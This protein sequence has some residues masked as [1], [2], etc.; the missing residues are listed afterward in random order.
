MKSLV[1]KKRVLTACL[2]GV[3][4]LSAA[5]CGEV[6]TANQAMP[7]P[8]DNDAM[9]QLST[10]TALVSGDYYGSVTVEDLLKRGDFGLGCFDAV[11]GEMIIND[12]VCYQALGDG[13]VQKADMNEKVPFA[14]L[15]KFENDFSEETGECADINALTEFLNG[16][17]EKRGANSMYAVKIHTTCPKLHVRSETKQEEPYIPLNEALKVSQTEFDYD[18]AT[19]TLVCLYFPEYMS[20][21]NSAGWHF[22]FISDDGTQG[23]HVLDLSFDNATAEFDEASE[24]DM[25]VPE[26]D[27]FQ[28]AGIDKVDQSSIDEAE[29]S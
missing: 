10:I 19:G 15:C 8:A 28:E 25:I 11:N 4:A 2:M 9:V 27:S 16:V 29:R 23:G 12:G 21:L 3:F 1:I 18:G 14:T 24:F 17:V 5:G 20:K 6:Q 13:T 7:K 26:T 22:H